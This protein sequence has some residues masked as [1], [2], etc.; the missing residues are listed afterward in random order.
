MMKLAQFVYVMIGFAVARWVFRRESVL[1]PVPRLRS[2]G[3]L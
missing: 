1:D 3:L 2:M